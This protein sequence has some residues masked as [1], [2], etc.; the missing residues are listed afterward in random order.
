V[1]GG[2]ADGWFNPSVFSVPA[3]GVFGNAGRNSL[4]GPGLKVADLSLFKNQ[5]FGRYG[6]QFRLEAFNAFNW[7]N[8]GLPDFTIFNAGGVLN[9]T[10]GRITRTATPAR[11]G[12]LGLKFPFLPGTTAGPPASPSP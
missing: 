9:P 1:G 3:A 10:A 11:Q 12:Q 6:M 8:L 5:R 7:V 2:T 4:R